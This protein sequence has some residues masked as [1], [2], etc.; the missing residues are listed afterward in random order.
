M[1][2]RHLIILLTFCTAFA[3][4]K[5]NN[6]SSEVVGQTSM[7]DV[8][9]VTIEDESATDAAVLPTY[10][11]PWVDQLRIRSTPGT[12]GAVLG[13][14]KEHES[15]EYLG[16]ETVDLH[17]TSLRGKTVKAPWIKVKTENGITGWIFGGATT[18]KAPA[19]DTAPSLFD[20]CYKKGSK[21][22]Q[23]DDDCIRTQARRQFRADKQFVRQRNGSYLFTLLDGTLSEFD[24]KSAD[25]TARVQTYEYM[26]YLNKMGYFVLKRNFYTRTAD[27]LLINDKTGQ[28][29]VI[30]GLPKVS[31]Q[32]N[33]LLTLDNQGTT[34]NLEIWELSDRGLTLSWKQTLDGERAFRPWWLDNDTVQIMVQSTADTQRAAD[35]QLVMRE[36][37]GEWWYE[38]RKMP[39]I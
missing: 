20:N 28:S 14:L 30:G 18:T 8:E 39:E 37:T 19:R 2:L 25:T 10:V 7:M 12:K 4:C 3:A 23:Q 16:E 26:F 31:P 34:S 38:D 36:K 33:Y 27:Y 35:T 6:N 22:W 32:G 17:E 21:R 5:D 15:L 11:Y 29:T 24:P 9:E 13:K 1:N